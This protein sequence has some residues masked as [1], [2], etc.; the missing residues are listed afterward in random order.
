LR[1]QITF[2]TGSQGTSKKLPTCRQALLC[3]LPMNPYPTSAMLSLRMIASGLI[4]RRMKDR[5]AYRPRFED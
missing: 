1:P 2:K 5:G 4:D 3:A